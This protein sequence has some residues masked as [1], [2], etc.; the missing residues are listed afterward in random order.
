MP[1]TQIIKNHE[2]SK[3]YNIIISVPARLNFKKLGIFNALLIKILGR[4]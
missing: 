2:N 1:K 3:L 4:S